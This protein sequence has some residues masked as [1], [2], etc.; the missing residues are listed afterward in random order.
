MTT[1]SGSKLA[2]PRPCGLTFS[3]QVQTRVD[4]RI[5]REMCPSTSSSTVCSGM[6]SSKKK[7]VHFPWTFHKSVLVGGCEAAWIGSSVIRGTCEG[8]V[9][10]LFWKLHPHFWGER[11]ELA[12]NEL[13]LTEKPIRL[14]PLGR[15][16]KKSQIQPKTTT[17]CIIK[18]NTCL[19]V[20]IPSK[21]PSKTYRHNFMMVF[22]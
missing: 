14:V 12:F 21:P 10:K 18:T 20:K 11:A 2:Q 5:W 4:W 13:V 16:A 1:Q 22:F 8:I 15:T 3:F 17:L 9:V 6:H 7:I 19:A